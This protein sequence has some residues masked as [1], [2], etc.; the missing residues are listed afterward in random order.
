M[1]CAEERR[2]NIAERK[3]I[4]E[5]CAS[6]EYRAEVAAENFQAAF[7]GLLV[8][9]TLVLSLWGFVAIVKLFWLHS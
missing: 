4:A 9:G 1:N 8:V 6:A 3:R 2:E 7:Y 5:Y